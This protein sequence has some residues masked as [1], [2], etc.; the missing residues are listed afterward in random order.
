M[1]RGWLELAMPGELMV[2]CRH[3]S[4]PMSVA[5]CGA[6]WNA[7]RHCRVEAFSV[8]GGALDTPPDTHRSFGSFLQQF[9][10]DTEL[11]A[12]GRKWGNFTPI[13]TLPDTPLK[14]GLA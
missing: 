4:P 10:F 2:S 5:Q 3:D 9:H 1:G 8:D 13:T 11:S 14:G 6:G 7:S 12:A